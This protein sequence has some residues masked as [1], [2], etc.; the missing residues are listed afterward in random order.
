MTP[1]K[2]GLVCIIDVN[3]NI[4]LNKHYLTFTFSLL[5]DK[6]DGAGGPELVDQ[7]DNPIPIKMGRHTLS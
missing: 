6:M 2:L 5:P 7:N 1:S 4:N 3:I